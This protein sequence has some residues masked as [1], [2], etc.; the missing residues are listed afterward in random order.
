[1]YSMLNP[2]DHAVKNLV[3]VFISP[4]CVHTLLIEDAVVQLTELVQL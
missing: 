1:M 2:K 3:K 4:A